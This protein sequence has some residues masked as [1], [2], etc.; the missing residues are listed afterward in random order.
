MSLVDCFLYFFGLCVR[1]MLLPYRLQS[2]NY[3]KHK[4]RERL[5]SKGTEAKI[6]ST[7]KKIPGTKKANTQN[8]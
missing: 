8:T 6:K 2:K 4:K 5:V 1:A 7:I 3:A